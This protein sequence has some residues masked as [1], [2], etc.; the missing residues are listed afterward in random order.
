MWGSRQEVQLYLL[1]MFI[2][3]NRIKTYLLVNIL[4][5]IHNGEKRELLKYKIPQKPENDDKKLYF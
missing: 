4:N 1:I 5:E 3:T 2:F